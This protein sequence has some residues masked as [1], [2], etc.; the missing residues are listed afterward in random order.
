MSKQNILFVGKKFLLQPVGGREMLSSLNYQLLI[1]IFNQNC[2]HFEISSNQPHPSKSKL[3]SKIFQG[4]IDGV[5][6]ELL[7][8]L[9]TQVRL[10][11]ISQI[12]IDGSNLGLVAQHL[13]KEF[14]NIKIFTFFHNIETK[15]FYD[16]LI[17]AKSLR[18]II[19]LVANYFAEKKSV[20]YSDHLICL[21]K[22]D[23]NIM[24]NFFNRKA[25]SI[26]PM[27]L[28]DKLNVYASS[29]NQMAE[30]KYVLFV[31]GLFYANEHGMRWFVKYIAP[32]ISY[33]IFIVGR[34]FETLKNEFEKTKNITVVGKV[35]DLNKWYRE[36]DC[37]IAP[38]FEG[39]GMKT[40]VAEALMF[41]KKIVASS[42][43]LEGYEDMPNN[44]CYCC[45]SKAAFIDTLNTLYN[46]KHLKFD[47]RIRDIYE[48]KF[49]F[50]AAKK[51]LKKILSA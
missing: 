40:K 50:L 28:V 44:I 41:G 33:K 3:F 38:I 36:S 49:S 46:E 23:S 25:D 10:Q 20:K 34:G 9:S 27:A 22:A 1:S 29:A 26:L 19:I 51:N 16:S 14:P 43:A 11:N 21:T 2:F 17:R 13:K 35:D 5:S 37:V 8:K 48:N 31:G 24:T 7:A 4:E 47:Q 30:E 32:N 18:S 45:N 39:S 15:F 12:F 42:S 6:K